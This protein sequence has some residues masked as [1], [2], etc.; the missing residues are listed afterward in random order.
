VH[1]RG[2]VDGDHPQLILQRSVDEGPADPD[3]RFQRGSRRWAAGVDSVTGT[4]N[5]QVE[6]VCGELPGQ[7]Q[8]DT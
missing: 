7:P 8:A 4:H 6:A 5:H 1:L 2:R 3:P